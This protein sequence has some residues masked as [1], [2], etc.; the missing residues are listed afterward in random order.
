[1]NH[2]SLHVYSVTRADSLRDFRL[3]TQHFAVDRDEQIARAKV[4]LESVHSVRLT[5]AHV[6][7]WEEKVAELEAGLKRLRRGNEI[8]ASSNF[9]LGV[10]PC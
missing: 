4:A 6:S 2:F 3:Q 5:R 1:M 9:S 7:A 8:S 10:S